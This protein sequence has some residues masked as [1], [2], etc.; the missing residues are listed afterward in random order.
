MQS[1]AHWRFLDNRVLHDWR[2][3]EN[4][5]TCSSRG[6]RPGHN[7]QNPDLESSSQCIKLAAAARRVLAMVRRNFWKLDVEDIL[8]VYKTHTASSWVLCPLS[9]HGLHIEMLERV[10]RTATRLYNSSGSSAVK[11][12]HRNWVSQHCKSRNNGWYDWGHKTA[13]SHRKCQFQP[14]LLSGSHQLHAERTWWKLVK[15]RTRLDQWIPGSFSASEWLTPGT[16]CLYELYM[17]CMWIFSKMYMIHTLTDKW[18]PKLTDARPS[19]YK[20]KYFTWQVLYGCLEVC[21][22]I[23]ILHPNILQ[24]M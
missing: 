5:T 3:N 20:Y 13:P 9:S 2:Y 17:Y 1:Q 10:Q 18:T 12:D 7:Y 23:C 14:V 22:H 21:S 24:G 6:K 11:R 4:S 15:K 16:V 8:I 19:A